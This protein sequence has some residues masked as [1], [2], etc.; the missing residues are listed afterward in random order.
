MIKA[1]KPSYQDTLI[2]RAKQTFEDC[3]KNPTAGPCTRAILEV[4]Q[5]TAQE[6]WK[7]GMAAYRRQAEKA[8]TQ[9]E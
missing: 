3:C 9:T 1:E 8:K 4:L 2:E 6:S 7:N 5:Q